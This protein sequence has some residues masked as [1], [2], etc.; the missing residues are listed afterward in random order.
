MKFLEYLFRGVGL[1]A[2]LALL[3]IAVVVILYACID[4][5]YFI[6]KILSFSATEADLI[7][8]TLKVVDLILL[9][10]SIFI[11]SVGI[12]ELFVKPLANLPPWLQVH[13]L[14]TL[15]S[16]L[17]KVAIV[18]LGIS[19]LGRAVTWNGQDDLL[20]YGLAVAAVVIAL[21]YFLGMKLKK[22]ED[23]EEKN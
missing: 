17:L 10:F 19:F 18:V 6:G 9:G 11:A 23:K 3:I 13:D 1:L 2:S 7:T 15:K 4:G 14:D 12:Y 16:M 21:S 5:L 8:K 22:E 20:N